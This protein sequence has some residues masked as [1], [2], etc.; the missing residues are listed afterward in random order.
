MLELSDNDFK[1][2]IITNTLTNYN[3]FK[4]ARERSNMK[5]HIKNM[6]MSPKCDKKTFQQATTNSFKINEKKSKVSANNKFVKY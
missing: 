5:L 1:A 6:K 3:F 2:T 4:K